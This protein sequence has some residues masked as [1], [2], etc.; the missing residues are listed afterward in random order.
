MAGAKMVAEDLT[1][2]LQRAGKAVADDRAAL[3]LSMVTLKK[4]VRRAVDA[5][6][7]QKD[8]AA[9]VGWKSAARVTQVLAEG[10]DE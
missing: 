10:D 6:M 7:S 4:V 9:A 5:G 2:Q 1:P 8:I 3:A